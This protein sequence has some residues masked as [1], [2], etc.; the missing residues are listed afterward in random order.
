MAVSKTDYQIQIIN[1]VKKLRVD[2]DISQQQ[3]AIILGATNGHIGNIESLKYGNKYTLNQLNLI[4]HYFHIPIEALFMN[5]G[6]QP[7][8]IADYTNK[9]CEYLE[10]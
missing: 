10:G 2:N 1:K 8:T 6:D 5:E 9:V 4:A 7:L 3:L